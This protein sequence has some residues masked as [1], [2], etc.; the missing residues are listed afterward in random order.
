MIVSVEGLESSGKTHFALTAPAPIV[1]LNLDNGLEGVR[2][3]ALF[4][5]KQVD[6]KTYPTNL[7]EGVAIDSAAARSWYSGIINQMFR[8]YRQ[9]IRDGA[10]TVVGDTGTEILSFLK[11]ANAEDKR[12]VEWI[13]TYRSLFKLAY[14]SEQTNL[15]LLHRMKPVWGKQDGKSYKKIG[16][17]E[18]DFYEGTP[19]DVQLRI[20]T[21]FKPPVLDNGKVLRPGMFSQDILKSRDNVSLLG[22]TLAPAL[23]FAGVCSLACPSVDW[24]K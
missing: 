1:Y 13:E 2:D 8:D 23:D 14:E 6:A 3:N 16:E 10:R 22:M 12:W 7:P 4:A 19:H 21:T 5:G 17:W 9:A 24:E 15:I 18:P 20:R 11:L